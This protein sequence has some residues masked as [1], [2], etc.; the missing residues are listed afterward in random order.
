LAR[1]I[2]GEEGVRF[3]ACGAD[4]RRQHLAEHALTPEGAEAVG[5]ARQILDAGIDKLLLEGRQ[6]MET[7]CLFQRGHGAA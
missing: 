1:A 7:A 6:Q 5:M 2:F 4:R 3:G